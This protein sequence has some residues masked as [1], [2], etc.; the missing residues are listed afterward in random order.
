MNK[1]I[2][3][4]PRTSYVYELVVIDGVMRSGKFLH[5]ALV[6]SLNRCEMWQQSPMIDSIPAL[7][8]LGHISKTR[9]RFP[10]QM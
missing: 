8:S 7:Y 3:I 6:S 5:D 4:Y 1:L 10:V 9:M 2:E